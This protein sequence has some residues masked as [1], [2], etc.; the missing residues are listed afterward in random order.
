MKRGLIFAGLA[1]VVLAATLW[2]LLGRSA[3]DRSK[4]SLPEAAT[5]GFAFMDLGAEAALSESLRQGLDERLGDGAL[6]KIGT[7]DLTF[8]HRGVFQD[9]LPDIATLDKA[10]NRNPK[11]RVEHSIVRLTYRYP[12]YKGTPF[13]LVQLVFARQ[14]DRPLCFKITFTREG[15]GAADAL[16]QKYGPPLSDSPLEG[17]G[18]LKRW[19]K[20]G[21]VMVLLQSPDRLGRPTPHVM[22][23]FVTAIQALLAREQDRES[24]SAKDGKTL[25]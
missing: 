25:F 1:L 23:Y 20:P 22:I 17:G 18:S 15:A 2:L 4:P 13:D 3:P 6:E 12:E 24:N 19:E 16:F 11:E 9:L 10:L 7:L 21:Q 14:D 8:D 5:T